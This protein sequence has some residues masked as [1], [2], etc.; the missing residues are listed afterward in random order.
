MRY[1]GLGC[2]GHRSSNITHWTHKYDKPFNTMDVNSSILTS[3]S[4]M[5]VF[6]SM[7]PCLTSS[8]FSLSRSLTLVQESLKKIISLPMV[9]FSFSSAEMR[10]LLSSSL[11][12]RISACCRS[13]LFSF[14]SSFLSF[15]SC[16]VSCSRVLFWD[17]SGE[18]KKGLAVD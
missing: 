7:E 11:E 18:D 13:R 1:P 9:R 8:L 6:L 3:L 2:V 16:E 15:S 12:S 5:R 17:G 4:A 10:W 14:S